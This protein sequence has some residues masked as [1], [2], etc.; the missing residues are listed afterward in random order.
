MKFLLPEIFPL[1]YGLCFLV[2]LWQAFRV[3]GQGFRAARS[4]GRGAPATEATGGFRDRTG[5]LTVHPELLDADGQL[6]RE[7]LLT[8]RFSGDNERPASSGDPA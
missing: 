7:D 8:V 5:Q 3:M 1:L 4:N 2:L 6:T